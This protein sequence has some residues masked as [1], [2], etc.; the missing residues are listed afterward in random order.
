MKLKFLFFGGEPL[1]EYE[2][3]VRF[4]KKLTPV[5]KENNIPYIF[6]M[7]TNGYSLTPKRFETLA[8]LRCLGYQITVDGMDFSHNKT[9]YLINKKPSW[10]KIM[11]NLQYMNSTKHPF[12]VTLRTNY[13]KD[14]FE[15]LNLFYQYVKEHFDDRFHIYYETI[16]KQGGE[17]DDE[18]DVVSLVSS[19]VTDSEITKILKDYGLYCSNLLERTLPCSIMCYASKPNFF[20]IDYDGSIKKCSHTLNEENNKIGQVLENGTVFI[21]DKLHARWTSDD[22][23]TSSECI[24]CKLLPLCFGR[25]CIVSKMNTSRISCSPDVEVMKLEEIISSYF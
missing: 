7:T 3:I 20:S 12:N 15:S 5:L 10:A 23:S 8:G 19:I 13:N 21:N 22:Y 9:R 1:L 24:D 14:V 25:K 6:S 2:N 11:K 17:K 18:F 4:L 16:K